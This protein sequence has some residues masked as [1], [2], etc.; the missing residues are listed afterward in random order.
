MNSNKCPAEEEEVKA[1]KKPKKEKV[2]GPIMPC[3][4]SS[5]VKYDGRTTL[6]K[7]EG[8]V[9]YKNRENL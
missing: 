7:A 6:E 5:R 8:Y 2:W 1:T 3:I 9:E 4:R